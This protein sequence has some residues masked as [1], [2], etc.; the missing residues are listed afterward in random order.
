MLRFRWRRGGAAEA[1]RTPEWRFGVGEVP[2]SPAVF[3]A[4][5]SFA[6]AELAV[7]AAVAALRRRLGHL[8][9][10]RSVD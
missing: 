2:A 7:D 10:C 3:A 8:V 6:S 4:E 9:G 1:V 5:S